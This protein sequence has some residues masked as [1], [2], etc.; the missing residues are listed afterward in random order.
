[1]KRRVIK[2]GGSLLQDRETRQKL[3]AW[4]CACTPLQ[5]VIVVGGGEL[6]DVIRAWHHRFELDESKSHELACRAL[7]VT[8]SLVHSWLPG[9]ILVDNF[10]DVAKEKHETV[11]FNPT[12]WI[13]HRDVTMSWDFTSDS[14]AALTAVKIQAGELLLLKSVLPQTNDLL[15]ATRQEYVDA[16][17]CELA[18]AI[19][20]VAACVLS[21]QRV[22]FQVPRN[23]DPRNTTGEA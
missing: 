4:L 11:V 20:S 18:A 23:Q 10:D 1:M 21:G 2:I 22:D 5:N 19:P 13:L 14:I 12:S 7:S 3:R 6:V 8:A 15:T 17:F 16:C 9:S